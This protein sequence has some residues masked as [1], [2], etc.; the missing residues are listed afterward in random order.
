MTHCISPNCRETAKPFQVLRETSGAAAAQ[1]SVGE[2][3]GNELPC[4]VQQC[5]LKSLLHHRSRGWW[6][7]LKNNCQGPQLLEAAGIRAQTDVLWARILNLHNCVPDKKWQKSRCVTAYIFLGF[8]IFTA[9]LP[10]CIL[11]TS[12]QTNKKHN[13]NPKVCLSTSHWG[14]KKAEEWL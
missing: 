2:A 5:K 4:C 8:R 13:R 11:K 7:S 12:K 9:V 3:S 14:K 6:D 10:N 1:T